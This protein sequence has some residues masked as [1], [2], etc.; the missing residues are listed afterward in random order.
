MM[1]PEPLKGKLYVGYDVGYM[2]TFDEEEVR[3]AVEWLLQEV[4]QLPKV[5]LQLAVIDYTKDK[6]KEA[7]PDVLEEKETKCN[8]EPD[9]TYCLAAHVDGSH[10]A[11]CR[12]CGAFFKEKK[13]KSIRKHLLSMGEFKDDPQEISDVIVADV[14][15]EIDK[16]TLAKIQE[17]KKDGY[18]DYIPLEKVK[19]QLFG[20]DKTKLLA[21]LDSLYT[22]ATA[23]KISVERISG[24][25]KR[26]DDLLEELD[27]IR[28]ELRGEES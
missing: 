10:C 22:R 16:K 3:A 24:A 1:K 12:K 13:P 21:R 14:Q 27:K 18:K 17:A 8:H 20:T 7:F 11:H 23:E 9:G 15:D 19:E 25:E 4:D 5:G 2:K 26:Y 6:I 28:K